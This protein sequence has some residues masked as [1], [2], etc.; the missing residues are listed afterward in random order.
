[1]DIWRRNKGKVNGSCG[2]TSTTWMLPIPSSP[3]APQPM[4]QRDA[5]A[6]V[7]YLPVQASAEPFG[8]GKDSSVTRQL[9]DIPC[10]V[11]YGGAVFA[12]F[13]VCLHP[14]AKFSRDLSF[15]IVGDFPPDFGT[16]DPQLRPPS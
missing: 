12:D 11:E 8:H 5:P 9:D 2:C 6:A 15:K 7:A 13:E 4:L 1:M 16:A 14:V 10:A 3:E